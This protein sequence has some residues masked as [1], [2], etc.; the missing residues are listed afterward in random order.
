MSELLTNI[1]DDIKSSMKSGEKEKLLCLRG[2]HSEI[3]NVSINTKVDIT[4]NLILD[5]LQKA[6]KQRQDASAQFASGGRQDL[7]DKNETEIAW[8]RA[9]MPK[10]LSPEELESIVDE[11][12]K[13]VGASSKK[14]MGKVMP[15]IMQKTKGQADGKA[16]SQLVSKKLV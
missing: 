11:V 1:L 6:V 5:V 12:I 14:D 7:V 13:E 2:L 15:A 9:Y 10:Q 8:L 16:I 3:K 4:D